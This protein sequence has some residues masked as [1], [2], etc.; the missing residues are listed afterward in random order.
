MRSTT[1]PSYTKSYASVNQAHPSQPYELQPDNGVNDS[2]YHCDDLEIGVPDNVSPWDLP[3]RHIAN[4]L[5]QTYLECVHPTFPIIGKRT[6]TSQ[7]QTFLDSN[8]KTKPGD[9]WAAILNLIFAIAA[10]YAQL[11]RAEWRGDGDDHLIYFTRARLLGMNSESIFVH[12]SL[13]TVQV[14]GLMSF[15][16]LTVDQINRRVLCARFLL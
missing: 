3:P 15:Y 4:L 8:G 16:F 9:N 1:K 11:A 7:A 12:P 5:L 14:T 2:S 10:K 13:Q 6:F